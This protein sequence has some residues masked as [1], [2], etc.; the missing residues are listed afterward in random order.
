MNKTIIVALII[1]FTASLILADTQEESDKN[2][3]PGWFQRVIE[4]N[5][6]KQLEIRTEISGK[7][8][9]LKKGHD[10]GL[11]MSILMVAFIYGIFHAIGPGHG[12]M[13]ISSYMLAD[14][15]K[16]WKGIIGGTVFAFVH[17]LSGIVLVM[18]LKLLSKNVF[19]ESDKFVEMASKISFG[20]LIVLGIYFLVMAFRKGSEHAH[21][22]KN[23]FVTILSVAL[24][25]CPG[26]VIISLFAMRMEMFNFGFVM[27]LSMALGMAVVI[28][29]ISLLTISLKESAFRVFLNDE[30]MK[31]GLVKGI[32]VFGSIMMILLAFLFLL[33]G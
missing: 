33:M 25:P 7:M 4:K 15:V 27:I 23:L 28:S 21:D 13:V 32:R 20:I 8:R 16:V 30:K 12:K 18:V 24:V 22:N 9:A 29:A 11:M 31:A 6:I 19:R 14:D 2:D 5:S 26:S 17:S 1:L 10:F 3:G